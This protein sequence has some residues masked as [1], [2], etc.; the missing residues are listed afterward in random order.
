MGFLA[1]LHKIAGLCVKRVAFLVIV[2]TEFHRLTLTDMELTMKPGCLELTEIAACPRLP[3]LSAG[4]EGL[5]Y[6][7]CSCLFLT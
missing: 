7:A 5:G 1:R 6:H 2:V 4:I 3:L